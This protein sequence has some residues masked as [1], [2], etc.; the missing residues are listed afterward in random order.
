MRPVVAALAFVTI[1]WIC[2]GI[3]LATSSA[4]E[5]VREARA[6]EAS[7]EN[8]LALRRYTE[9]LALDPTATDAYLGLA[10]LRL[11]L[12]QPREAA[13]VYATA[14]EHVPTLDAALAGR[15]R[16][17]R[18]AGIRD[19]AALDLAA[20][21]HKTGDTSAWRELAGW[22]EEDGLFAA[23]LA[24][25]RTLADR[26]ARTDDATLAARAA[27]TIR[28]LVALVKPV[29]PAAFP[30]SSDPTR[31]ALANIAKRGG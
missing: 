23:E 24:V 1:T 30:A 18:A 16:A 6:H 10:A 19:L 28:A 2:Q 26:A 21:A 8:E 31:R 27:K 3:A 13:T 15:A 11:R 22:Y 25:W 9:A 14:L 29:D 5:L 20:Y 17:R 7:H 4:D 12:G